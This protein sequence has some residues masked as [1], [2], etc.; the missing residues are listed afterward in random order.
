MGRVS[1]RAW[2]AAYR[3]QMPDDYLDELS[4]EERARMWSST[5]GRRDDSRPVLVVE[6]DGTVIGFA[7]VGP[8]RDGTRTGELYAINI[9]P[10]RWGSGHGRRLL[11]AAEAELSAVGYDEV[12]LWVVP[13]NQRARRF[14]ES[15]GWVNDGAERTQEILG[16][17]VPEIRY[18]RAL[19]QGTGEPRH[20]T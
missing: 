20:S 10:D 16:V 6:H 15:A 3:G 17:I 2:Q 12:V 19:P 9:D 7:S 1:V 14:Y 11:E 18:R 8:A 4:P 5:L 13:G